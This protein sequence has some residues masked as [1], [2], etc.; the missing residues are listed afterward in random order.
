M[1]PHNGHKNTIQTLQ[2]KSFSAMVFTAWPKPNTCPYVLISRMTNTEEC[3][4]SET[5]DSNAAAVQGNCSAT[6]LA[7]F[8]S[9]GYNIV[10]PVSFCAYDKILNVING[11]LAGITQGN[12]SRYDSVSIVFIGQARQ[13]D[14]I[15]KV[16]IYNNP[17]IERF[18]RGFQPQPAIVHAYAATHVTKNSTILGPTI[19]KLSEHPNDKVSTRNRC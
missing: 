17:S 9:Q 19:L 5:D 16:S 8:A 18:M 1:A 14:A 15:G 13:I 10:D 7:S 12:S 3:Y 2:G 6:G 4:W 11:N